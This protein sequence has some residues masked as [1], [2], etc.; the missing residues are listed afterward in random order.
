MCVAKNNQPARPY[1]Y[2]EVRPVPSHYPPRRV[3]DFNANGS[4]LIHKG[5]D[6]DSWII[7]YPSQPCDDDVYV[8]YWDKQR[9]QWFW[10]AAGYGPFGQAYD[11][12]DE[13]MAMVILEYFGL[14]EK[15]EEYPPLR[16]QATPPEELLHAAHE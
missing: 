13:N 9:L 16:L 3:R 14:L 8:V 11:G 15:S 7:F 12:L 4:N 1:I 6:C 10:R 5:E 2:R